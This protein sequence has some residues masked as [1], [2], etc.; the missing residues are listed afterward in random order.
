[1]RPQTAKVGGIVNN[2]RQFSGVGNSSE[3][4]NMQVQPP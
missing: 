1:M 2:F 4:V 3:A